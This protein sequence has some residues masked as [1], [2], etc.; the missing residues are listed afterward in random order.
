MLDPNMNDVT[1][2]ENVTTFED[3]TVFENVTAFEKVI[4]FEKISGH[5][6]RIV[7]ALSG[8]DNNKKKGLALCHGHIHDKSLLSSINH[9]DNW[10]FVDIDKNAQP[11]YICDVTDPDQMKYFP[12]KY[13]D[14]IA[15]IHCPI[16]YNHKNQYLEIL[17][18]IY[19]IIND[20]GDIYLTELP[21]LFYWFIDK[22]QCDKVL[23][24]C[25]NEILIDKVNEYQKKILVD[26]GGSQ[27]NDNIRQLIPFFFGH[28]IDSS[29]K[30]MIDT[31]VKETSL[32]I[33]KDVLR[34]NH[35]CIVRSDSKF[36]II[37]KIDREIKK[38]RKNRRQTD[39]D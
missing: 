7:K 4:A 39:G 27:L 25:H 23:S 5:K 14:C 8:I 16:I 31:F 11:D 22:R 9:I 35:F 30:K 15:I 19:R 26:K 36:L 24:E 20:T 38:S 21:S 28:I 32:S 3:I 18:N 2:F 12:D 33:T 1:A 17:V 10:Y 37:R 34:K 13:F 6:H 29:C